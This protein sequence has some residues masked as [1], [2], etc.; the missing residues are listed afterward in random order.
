M[1]RARKDGRLFHYKVVA[2]KMTLVAGAGRVSFFK[3]G[4]AKASDRNYDNETNPV[5]NGNG[6]RIIGIT[7][8]F[9]A[10][11][12]GVIQVRPSTINILD[13]YAKLR[14]CGMLELKI[15]SDVVHQDLLSTILPA[16]PIVFNSERAG[17]NAIDAYIPPSVGMERPSQSN[18]IL[19]SSQLMIP[20]QKALPVAPSESLELE[21]SFMSDVTIPDTLAGYILEMR[22]ISEV[23]LK[24]STVARA[25]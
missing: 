24:G 7:A 14:N 23:Y 3:K 18:W 9:H 6:G 20:F 1:K 8:D 17:T 2:S 5:T 22:L 21:L 19:R 12:N 13:G 25:E 10:P 11:S 15:G 16:P 4:E